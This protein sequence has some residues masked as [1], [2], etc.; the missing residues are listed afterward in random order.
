MKNRIESLV[1]KEI[2]NGNFEELN[3]LLVGTSYKV[4]NDSQ[5]YDKEGIARASLSLIFVE[6]DVVRIKQVVPYG[7]HD[8][9]AQLLI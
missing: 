4:K 2:R 9:L 3:S 5:I 1:S 6:D 7:V 8:E